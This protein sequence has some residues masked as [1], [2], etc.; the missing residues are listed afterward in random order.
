MGEGPAADRAGERHPSLC[1]RWLG[2]R[3]GALGGLA[4]GVVGLDDERREQLV[5]AGEVP[6]DR[7]GRH[8]ERP[9]DGPKRQVG[10]DLGELPAGLAHDLLGDLGPGTC[11]GG[12]RGAGDGHGCIMHGN[13]SSGNNHEQCS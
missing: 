5:A 9:R 7:R 11:P 3:G 2:P 12:G 13:E 4:D 6:V 1:D 8:A 10:A